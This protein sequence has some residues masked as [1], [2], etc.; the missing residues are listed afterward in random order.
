MKKK[1]LRLA[2]T[3]GILGAVLLPGAAAHADY[4]PPPTTVTIE[5]TTS[6]SSSGTTVDPNSG[7]NGN[8]NGSG[9]L[10]T[11]GSDAMGMTLI[12]AGLAAGGVVLVRANRRRAASL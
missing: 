1:A 8:G 11:T 9:N 10:P 5:G 12:G 2:A 7:G 3:A 6:T 4:P